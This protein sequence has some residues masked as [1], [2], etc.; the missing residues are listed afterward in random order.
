M[1]DTSRH[2]NKLNRMG[3]RQVQRIAKRLKRMGKISI[4][5]RKK[6]MVLIMEIEL[7]FLDL[8]QRDVKHIREAAAAY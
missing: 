3:Y 4:D 5:L 1:I 2:Y 8:P 7:A 6:K